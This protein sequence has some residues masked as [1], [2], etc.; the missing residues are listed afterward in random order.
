MTKVSKLKIR[1]LHHMKANFADTK[2][3][4]FIDIAMFSVTKYVGV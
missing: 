3:I 2:T 1:G 4:L